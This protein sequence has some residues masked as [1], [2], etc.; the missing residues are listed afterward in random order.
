LKQI[1]GFS[2][3]IDSQRAL[4]YV[5]ERFPAEDIIAL[6]CNAGGNEHPLTD[7]FIDQYSREVF[8]ITRVPS[9]V[10]DIWL[11]PGFA[12]T[13]GLDGNAELDFELMIRLKGRPPSRK[14]Q[15]C[16]EILKL[17]P[18]K[19]W[20]LENVTDE[21]ERWTGV[22]R[23]ESTARKDTPMRE[24][25]DYFDCYVNHP[26]AFA[27]KQY[28][29]DL[30]RAAGEPINPLY[31]LGF[32][33]VGCAPCINSG[34]DD[35]Q[36]WAE[37]FPEMIDKIRAWERSTGFTFFA[38]CVPG[39]RPRLDSRGKA[40]IFNWIDEVVEWARTDRGGYQFNVFKTLERPACESKFGLCE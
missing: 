27:E 38:P 13:K 23:D 21:Y 15:F 22:R 4:L 25:D 1:V 6:N 24:W 32:G 3:G 35:I 36:N 37:R 28:C 10:K 11:T 26:L 2:G 40:N 20:V 39:I 16:T 8:P 30:V 19:R 18:Q 12:E 7:A 31:S 34:K 29:F 5:R 9:L 14:A 33:R 17:R